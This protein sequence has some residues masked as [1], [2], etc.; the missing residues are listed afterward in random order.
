MQATITPVLVAA[1]AAIGSMRA[2]LAVVTTAP[3]THGWI[4]PSGDVTVTF[5][6]PIDPATVTDGSFALFGSWSGPAHGTIAIAADRRSITLQTARP[7]FAGELATITLS[8]QIATSGGVHLAHGYQARVWVT[9]APGSRSFGTPQILPLR[10]PNES[11]IG[12]YGIFAGDLD[13]D[14]SPDLTSMNEISND[15]RVQHNS[16]CGQFAPPIVV[17]N[18]GQWPSPNRGA[19]FDRDGYLDLVTGNQNGGAISIYRNDR[20]G[21]FVAPT[22]YP[23]SGY[24][25]GVATADFDGDGYWD[26]AAPNSADVSVFLNQGDGTFGLPVS[27]D[28]GGTGEDNVSAVDVDG[29]GIVDLV[30]GNLFSNT[31]GIL[32]GL[33]DGTFAPPQTFPTGGQPF[34]QACGDC[35]GDGFVDVLFANRGTN[36]FAILF[37]DGTGNF[38][39]P[40]TYP[41]GQTPAAIEVGD[42]DGDGHLDCIVANYSSA[43][44]SIWWNRGDG[45]FAQPITLPASQSGSCSTLVDFD[46]DGILDI[47]GAD[48][49][50]DVAIL[51]RQTDLAS[52]TS[53]PASCNATLRLNQRADRAGFGATPP[54]PLHLGQRLTIGLSGP[55]SS[56]CLLG[57]GAPWPQGHPVP[58]AGVVGLDLTS[59]LYLEVLV[60][61]SRGERTWTI[62]VPPDMPVGLRLAVQAA[63]G[64][65]LLLL[66]NPQGLIVVP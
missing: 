61:D 30:V 55:D 48:E 25:H 38:S 52:T 43:D 1:I 19:D 22:V 9:S 47:I 6:Q 31:M 49:N 46:R 27:Y 56:I 32:L 17:S 28:G 42:L 63:I 3:A 7:L 16:G 15:I 53:E 58:L 59:T 18:P 45:V 65:Q 34:H 60:L 50:A 10:L 29:D 4:D 12:T 36:T 26:V 37:G 62:A 11:R 35:D 54:Q 23:T 51:Y 2:Q 39:A 24:V 21:S 64:Q 41:V 66:S 20:S 8:H 13:G 57:I 44:Y 40:V 33:G 5:S 14:G